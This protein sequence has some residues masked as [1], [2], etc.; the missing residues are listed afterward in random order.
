MP[1]ER[2]ARDRRTPRPRGC[3][4]RNRGSGEL[5][6]LADAEGLKGPP[7]PSGAVEN[8]GAVGRK[9]PRSIVP[10][11]N[12]SCVNVRR[13][14]APR[15]P[16]QNPAP[17]STRPRAA[18]AAR[19][20]RRNT[21]F[22]RAASAGWL[23]EVPRQGFEVEGDVPGRSE[24]GRRRLLQ[25]VPHDPVERRGNAAPGIGRD[26]AGSSRGSAL[27]VSTAESPLNARFPDNIS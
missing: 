16:S 9:A 14:D 22:R 5:A 1:A 7:A 3:P 11:W 19:S 12:V 4:P 21:G 26:P 8:R 18:I 6:V 25:A 20:P 27:I 17:R 15:L 24:A 10:R 23:C 2:E 13:A